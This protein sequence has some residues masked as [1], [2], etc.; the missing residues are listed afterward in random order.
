MDNLDATIDSVARNFCLKE[1]KQQQQQQNNLSQNTSS[2][3]LASPTTA[4]A[5]TTQSA[6]VAA[7]SAA[8]HSPIVIT[9]ES[10][11]SPNSNKRALNS[12]STKSLKRTKSTSKSN[13]FD[14]P[15]P[16]SVQNNETTVNN[17]NNNNNNNTPDTSLNNS[18]NNKK[19]RKKSTS[20]LQNPTANTNLSQNI[21]NTAPS[22]DNTVLKVQ[23]KTPT[24]QEQN[25]V[26]KPPTKLQIKKPSL[27]LNQYKHKR[28]MYL[29][30]ARRNLCCKSKY[31]LNKPLYNQLKLKHKKFNL[32]NENLPLAF[33]LI[34][35][36][37][38][39]LC[40]NNLCNQSNSCLNSNSIKTTSKIKCTCNLTNTNNKLPQTQK[41]ELSSAITSTLSSLSQS[42]GQGS[43]NLG[44]NLLHV[45]TKF[46]KQP[47]HKRKCYFKHNKNENQYVCESEEDTD[48]DVSQKFIISK[49]VKPKSLK[50]APYLTSKLL[51]IKKNRLLNSEED[52]FSTT[53]DDSS[54]SAQSD[55]DEDDFQFDSNEEDFLLSDDFDLNEIGE[56]STTK[57]L[58]SDNDEMFLE[59]LGVYESNNNNKE[60]MK[61][62]ELREEANFQFFEHDSKDSIFENLN[63][64]AQKVASASRIVMRPDISSDSSLLCSSSS[65]SDAESDNNNSESTSDDENENFLSSSSSNDSKMSEENNPMLNFDSPSS[66]PSSMVSSNMFNK[67]NCLTN[68]TNKRTLIQKNSNPS[69]SK[70]MKPSLNLDK[71]DPLLLGLVSNNN[72]NTNGFY[73]NNHQ[74]E[75]EN[76]TQN[77]NLEEDGDESAEKSFDNLYLYDQDPSKFFVYSLGQTF[78][79]CNF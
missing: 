50:N 44:D 21:P 1:S 68:L 70:I 27:N 42:L 36:T 38:L 16:N 33:D 65:E 31:N 24:K 41:K 72:A 35:K 73:E 78:K 56:K 34:D 79:E 74:N 63:N 23:P 5:A 11:Q 54:Q 64:N 53:D 18:S 71:F 49:I 76:T 59:E 12:P 69:L 9:N 4:S 8:R 51:K 61:Q 47:F 67:R 66:S 19:Q 40:T 2:V 28:R 32:L 7:A 37:T 22:S 57:L 77:Q 30:Q 10:G 15:A 45:Q 39:N 25:L 14:S 29:K 55:T 3:I 26:K 48:E 60:K 13:L 43:L 17:N 62:D 52:G 20:N 6:V 58:L 75:S 46:I